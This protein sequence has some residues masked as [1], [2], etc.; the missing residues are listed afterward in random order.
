MTRHED[1]QAVTPV[2]TVSHCSP[3]NYR[4]KHDE[5]FD[6]L[7]NSSRYYQTVDIHGDTLAMAT[8]EVY[9]H[10][11]FDSLQIVKGTPSSVALVLPAMRT[12]TVSP[13]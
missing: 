1:G 10:T 7:D 4:I 6:M 3:K 9:G 11:L 2:Y 5:R 12:R 13:M 8:Y